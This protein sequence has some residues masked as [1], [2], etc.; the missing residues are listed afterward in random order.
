MAH[1]VVHVRPERRSP[2]RH[3]LSHERARGLN[4]QVT[5]LDAG[6]ERWSPDRSLLR[7]PHEYENK[8]CVREQRF[9]ATGCRAAPAERVNR[10]RLSQGDTPGLRLTCHLERL[11]LKALFETRVARRTCCQ[12]ASVETPDPS[13][14]CP[15]N[16]RAIVPLLSAPRADMRRN[17]WRARRSLMPRDFISGVMRCRASSNF[18]R[19]AAREVSSPTCSASKRKE[20][21]RLCHPL[22]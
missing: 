13:R 5:P 2:H 8:D 6:S 14:L 16:T 11:I 7:C 10:T 19:A 4:W 9:T 3:A 20:I 21:E 15:L 22:E 18:A 17:D 1:A 12:R